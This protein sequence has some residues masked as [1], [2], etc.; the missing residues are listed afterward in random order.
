MNL[1]DLLTVAQSEL[2]EM[3]N[4]E[5]PDFRLEQA[6]FLEDENIWEIVVSFLVENTNPKN[7]PFVAMTSEFKFERI[8]KRLKIDENKKVVAFF[9]FEK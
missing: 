3:S 6:V 7:S 2:K 9:M 8:Y 4:L 1:K 5:N